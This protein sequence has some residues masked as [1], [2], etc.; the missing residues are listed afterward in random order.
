V[1]VS[2]ELGRPG[3][4]PQTTGSPLQET[5]AEVARVLRPGGTLA[6]IVPTWPLRPTDLVTCSSPAW[7]A[8]DRCPTTLDPDAWGG[9]RRRRAAAALVRLPSSMQP[10]VPL[11]RLVAVRQGG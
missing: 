2:R 3:T 7:V 11:L 10:P 5:L 1:A 4:A 8:Q 6:A 9:L